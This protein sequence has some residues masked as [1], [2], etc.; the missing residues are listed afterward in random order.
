[1]ER[2]VLNAK[3]GM[4]MTNGEIYGKEI[5]L[6]EGVSADSFYEITEAEYAEA[7]KEHLDS[8][9]EEE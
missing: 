6:A 9:G 4:V 3:N 2:I 7:V 8:F 1:M 5:D